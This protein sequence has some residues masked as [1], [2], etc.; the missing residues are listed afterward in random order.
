MSDDPSVEAAIDFL[1]GHTCADIRFDGHVE[2]IKFVFAP[3]GRLVAP[4]M[5]A[6]LRAVD[7]SLAVPEDRAEAMELMV[8]LEAFEEHGEHGQLADRWRIY[9]GSPPDVRWARMAVDAARFEGLFIDGE[10]F[11]E[12]NALAGEEAALCR[13]INREHIAE[14]KCLCREG[15][16][17]DVERPLLVGVDKRGADVRTAFDILRVRF[18]QPVSSVVEARAMIL[19]AQ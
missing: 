19:S 13:E 8:T 11:G 7:T 6:M 14:L 10:P 9:H 17:M 3:D 16:G 2:R 18:R 15:G 1:H 4:V 5:V 12:G